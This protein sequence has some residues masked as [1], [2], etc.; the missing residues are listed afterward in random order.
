[1]WP[2][3]RIKKLTSNR[4]KSVRPPLW[5]RKEAGV[6]GI[7]REGRGQWQGKKTRRETRRRITPA[8]PSAGAGLTG[9]LESGAVLRPILDPAR[10]QVSLVPAGLGTSAERLLLPSSRTR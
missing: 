6:G 10:S 3:R 9:R 4:K 1:M 8:F 5:H 7:L 2:V